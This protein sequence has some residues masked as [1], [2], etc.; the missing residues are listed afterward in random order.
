MSAVVIPLPMEH[1]RD[2][3]ATKI[4]PEI[5]I[6]ERPNK[7]FLFFSFCYNLKGY[8]VIYE[9]VFFVLL[10]KVKHYFF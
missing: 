10:K 8:T 9:N 2:L 6:N 4:K 1:L 7:P 5:A 3:A